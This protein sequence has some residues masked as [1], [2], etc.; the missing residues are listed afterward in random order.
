[1]KISEVCYRVGFKYP[2]QLSNDFKRVTG[3]YPSEYF[4]EHEK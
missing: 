2:Q 1:M 4:N 3:M